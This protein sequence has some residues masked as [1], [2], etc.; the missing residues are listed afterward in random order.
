MWW[1]MIVD[2]LLNV[3]GISTIEGGSGFLPST[4]WYDKWWLMSDLNQGS[5]TMSWHRLLL[6]L[7]S[8]RVDRIENRYFVDDTRQDYS[9]LNLLLAMI[10]AHEPRI[11][12]K[13]SSL[14]K[15][16]WWLLKTMRSITMVLI[17]S[18]KWL[19]NLVISRDV[20][21]FF[22]HWHGRLTTWRRPWHK[23]QRSDSQRLTESSR[24]SK[25]W[26]VEIERALTIKDGGRMGNNYTWYM[27]V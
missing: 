6:R 3:Y 10:I 11:P 25:P 22:K 12:I 1:R 4:A 14:S 21:F 5:K 26:E 18:G 24:G 8:W 13:Y 23:R 15:C 2:E 17:L 16:H 7:W 27:S 19:H 20:D 9:T